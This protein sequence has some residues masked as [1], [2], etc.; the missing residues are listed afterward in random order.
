MAGR[1]MS[2]D[3]NRSKNGVDNRWDD[4]GFWMYRGFR[5]NRKGGKP[6]GGRGWRR[7]I[8]SKESQAVAREIRTEQV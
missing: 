7:A 2:S 4:D 1:M 3:R 8:R 5:G 6:T